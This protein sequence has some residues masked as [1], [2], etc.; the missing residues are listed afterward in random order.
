[1]V[2]FSGVYNPVTAEG[3]MIVDGIH[4]SC[5]GSYDHRVAHMFCAPLR[6]LSGWLTWGYEDLNG[7]L[8]F[9]TFIKYMAKSL[10]LDMIK[11]N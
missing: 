3:T 5:Y 10:P 11:S 1:M 8:P 9:I 6:W 7:T 4:V 2:L